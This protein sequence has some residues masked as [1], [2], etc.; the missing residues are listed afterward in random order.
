MIGSGYSSHT[1]STLPRATGEW[2]FN[3]TRAA[4]ISTT[5]TTIIT[6]ATATATTTHHRRRHHHH[7]PHR[8]ARAL[9]HTHARSGS[10]H[11]VARF[12]LD[13]PG[14]TTNPRRTGVPEFLVNASAPLKFNNYSD[15]GGGQSPDYNDRRLIDTLVRFIKE[16]GARYNNDT[17]LGA[18]QVGLLGFWGEWHT[19]P[20]T[21]WFP[22]L[23][24]QAEIWDAYLEAF[25]DVQLQTR[26]P[27]TV[28]ASMN[29]SRLGYHDD[30][31]CYSTLSDTTSWY[32]WP[33]VESS[34]NEEFWKEASMGG[35]MRPELQSTIFTS[36]YQH[37]EYAQRW[38]E[39]VDST[40]ASMMLFAYAFNTGELG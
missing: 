38:N 25:P 22:P 21:D 31:F 27:S 7:G 10:R 37:G 16:F 23:E 24:T 30:S 36:E 5:T 33:T 1:S 3:P 19:Y 17:R 4:V 13:Y 18:I 6:A 28:T 40:H 29:R 14:Q 26:S 20:H 32:F 9:S 8:A 11:F 39:T 35:E 12:Y 34:G 15:Y 2:S